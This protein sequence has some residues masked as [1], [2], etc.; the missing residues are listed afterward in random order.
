ML[1]NLVVVKKIAQFATECKTGITHNSLDKIL[2]VRIC[3]TVEK[4][5]QIKMK[6][7]ARERERERERE[8][9]TD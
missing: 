5:K 2:L 3:V 6:S 1:V 9:V 4:I 8:R 7:G